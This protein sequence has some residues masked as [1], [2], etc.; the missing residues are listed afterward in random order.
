MTVLPFRTP[1]ISLSDLKALV[2]WRLQGAVPR[3]PESAEP[4]A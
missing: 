2:D 1:P 4:S 3:L